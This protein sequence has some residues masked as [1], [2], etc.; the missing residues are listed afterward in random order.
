MTQS[1]A[2]ACFPCAWLPC[3]SLHWGCSWMSCEGH[4]RLS[5]CT[6][7]PS[8]SS[9]PKSTPSP[10]P[11]SCTSCLSLRCHPGSSPIASSAGTVFLPFMAFVV[12]AVYLWTLGGLG[13]R[14][15][16]HR[17]VPSAPNSAWCSRNTRD[18][19][20][21]MKEQAQFWAKRV[22]ERPGFLP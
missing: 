13:P 9:S 8:H 4:H 11:A 19:I 12:V 10:E 1:R 14:L 5:A 17:G 18:I 2:R 21:W 20:E 3:T 16:F 7:Q 6:S 22:L 15:L